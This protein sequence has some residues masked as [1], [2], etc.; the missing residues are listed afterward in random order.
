MVQ[1][2]SMILKLNKYKKPLLLLSAE[3]A[4]VN[5]ETYRLL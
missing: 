5:R 4:S 3:S 1:C 2:H